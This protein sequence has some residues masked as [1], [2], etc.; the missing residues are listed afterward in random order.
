MTKGSVTSIEK[1][2]KNRTITFPG[3]F[4]I[5]SFLTQAYAKPAPIPLK[6]PERDGSVLEKSKEGFTTRIAPE[7]AV[8]IAIKGISFIFSRRSRIQKK[9]VQKGAILFKIL[10]SA[11][12]K[13]S[14]A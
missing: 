4:K 2:L 8:I 7:K 9:R 13:W 6:K 11:K 1:A 3:H 10:A 5:P 12:I 14:M